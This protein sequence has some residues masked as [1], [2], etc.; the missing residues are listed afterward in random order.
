MISSASIATM[1]PS[2]CA[3]SLGYVLHSIAVDVLVVHFIKSTRV[4]RRWCGVRPTIRLHPPSV[5]W[6]TSAAIWADWRVNAILTRSVRC[7]AQWHG[8]FMSPN[9]YSTMCG[10]R[11]RA[12]VACEAFSYNGRKKHVPVIIHI[13]PDL[14]FICYARSSTG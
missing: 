10:T 13:L 4:S 1:P 5:P 12:G 8:S 14:S 7:C 3:S 2:I 9:V 11:A 6:R